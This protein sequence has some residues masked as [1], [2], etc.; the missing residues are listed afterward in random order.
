MRDRARALSTASPQDPTPLMLQGDAHLELGEY[1]E[2]AMA[3]Q[4]AVD[5]APDLRSYGR[6]AYLRWLRGDVTGAIS[7]Y[8]DALEAASPHDPEAA[9]FT[10]V[11]LGTVL[12]HE[13]R[14]TEARRAAD[15]ALALVPDYVAALGLL[16]R[17]HATAGEATDALAALDRIPIDRRGVEELGLHADLLAELGREPEAAAASAAVAAK[18]GEDPRGVALYWARHGTETAAAVEL[19][20]AEARR[21]PAIYSHAAL[22]LALARAGRADEA[23]AAWA[24]ATALGTRDARFPLYAAIVALEAGDREA[25]ERHSREARPGVDP[26]LAA[27]LAPVMTA[28]VP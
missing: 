15:A 28:R 17:T 10:Y 7:L 25:G 12:W 5:L 4:A 1:D 2:A 3:Y 13:G 18:K 19:A 21:R 26:V 20:A 22:A 8:E 6:G 24:K 27:E 14:L 16:A 23:R 11:D 9:A